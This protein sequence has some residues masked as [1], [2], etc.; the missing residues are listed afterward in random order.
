MALGAATSPSNLTPRSTPTSPDQ[1]QTHAIA[2]ALNEPK[3]CPQQPPAPSFGTPTPKT[4]RRTALLCSNQP[5]PLSHCPTPLYSNQPTIA[6]KQPHAPPIQQPT[7]PLYPPPPLAIPRPEEPSG[8]LGPG[9]TEAEA[10]PHLGAEEPLGAKQSES[11]RGG[12]VVQRAGGRRGEGGGV[13]RQHVTQLL[14]IGSS[15]FHLGSGIVVSCL[16]F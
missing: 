9:P 1:A 14:Y 7:P 2:L 12:G 15:S 13:Q 6:T 5:T 8:L 4:I 3:Y 16:R 11:L 10:D